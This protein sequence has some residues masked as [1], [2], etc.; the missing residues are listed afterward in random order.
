MTPD[1][2]PGRFDAAHILQHTAYVTGGTSGSP[3]F[4][5]NGAAIGIN[6]G[7]LAT[8]QEVTLGSG[9]GY[10]GGGSKV[11]LTMPAPGYN[12]GMRIDL[13]DDIFGQL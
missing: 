12:Y 11:Q 10:G 2:V 8:K 4:D 7:G 3:I 6:A 9:G 13:L 1:K 5:L